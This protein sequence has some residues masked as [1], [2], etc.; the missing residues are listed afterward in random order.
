MKNVG[1][2]KKSKKESNKKTAIYILLNAIDEVS[3]FFQNFYSLKESEEEAINDVMK[4]TL[5]LGYNDVIIEEIKVIHIDDLDEIE[6]LIED[7]NFDGF[8]QNIKEAYPSEE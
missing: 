3:P 8:I 1:D 6:E 4:F 7:E 2:Q 5:F